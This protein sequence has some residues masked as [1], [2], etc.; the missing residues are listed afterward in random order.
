M[1]RLALLLS[2]T[3]H[4]SRWEGEGGDREKV[5]KTAQEAESEVE[6]CSCGF[7]NQWH[8]LIRRRTSNRGLQEHQTV[9][10]NMTPNFTEVTFSLV[11]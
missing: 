9:V 10:Y 7:D 3:S 6:E 11:G 1:H 5:I 2:E 8:E 4:G